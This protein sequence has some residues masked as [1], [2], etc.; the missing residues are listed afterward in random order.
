MIYGH[1]GLPFVRDLAT[2]GR[3]VV[4]KVSR[5]VSL[6]QEAVLEAL[7]GG[8]TDVEMKS[9]IL[10]ALNNA[11]RPLASAINETLRFYSFQEKKGAVEKIFLC[12]GFSL[13]DTFVEFFADALPVDVQLFNPFEHIE[14]RAGDDGN[15]LLT[16]EGSAMVVAA[17]LAMRTL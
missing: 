1:D 16:T 9:K 2:A 6:P 11:V 7:A 13:F 10:L 5:E 12:G 17:G 15:E 3:Q 8:E 4:E 14:C